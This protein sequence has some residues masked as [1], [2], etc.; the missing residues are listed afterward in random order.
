MSSA[1]GDLLMGS[2]RDGE[3]G[4]LG[5]PSVVGAG[6]GRGSEERGGPQPGSGCRSA[7]V[8]NRL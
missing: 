2:E 7:R 1:I 6:R 4:G 3:A 8:S 5:S